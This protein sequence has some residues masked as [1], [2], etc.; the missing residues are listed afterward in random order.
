MD[1]IE[2]YAENI[3]EQSNEH[4]HH[5]AHEGGKDKWVIFVAM[6][7]AVIAVLA[8]ITGLLAGDHA[9]E[10]MLSQIHASDQWAFYQAKGIKSDVIA[11]GDKLMLALGKKPSP[12]DSA[13]ISSN[14][15]D[16]AKIMA[17]AKG[18]EKESHEHSAKHKILARGVTLFQI[19]IA[20]GAISIIVKRKVLWVVSVGFAAVGIYFLLQG[21]AF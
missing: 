5:A 10:A 4:A 15:A 7:T 12:Q 2:N 6:T 13:K 16:Q 17:E 9:D 3:H 19:A 14:K 11:Q 18:A 1:E 20:I 21:V 8:A